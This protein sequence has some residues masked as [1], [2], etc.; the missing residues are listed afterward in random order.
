MRMQA[1]V[2]QLLKVPSDEAMHLDTEFYDI[3]GSRTDAMARARMLKILRQGGP[4]LNMAKEQLY[5][6]IPPTTCKDLKIGVLG[7][8]LHVQHPV[9]SESQDALVSNAAGKLQLSF[10]SAHT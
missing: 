3:V 4:G 10:A 9:S 6:S 7:Q 1:G 2:Q 8:P 5:I